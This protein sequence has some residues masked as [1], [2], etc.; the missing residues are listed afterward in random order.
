MTADGQGVGIV[1]QISP[2]RGPVEDLLKLGKEFA[3]QLESVL[4]H[5]GA[6]KQAVEA[7]LSVAAAVAEV[8]LLV[9]FTFNFCV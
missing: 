6:E 7:T 1:L 8:S 2:D 4:D 3:T 5:F 9:A